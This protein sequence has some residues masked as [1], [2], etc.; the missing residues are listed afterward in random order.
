MK[1]GE[2]DPDRG[3]FLDT[4]INGKKCRGWLFLDGGGSD[5]MP[6][7]PSEIGEETTPEEWLEMCE[8]AEH[9]QARGQCWLDWEGQ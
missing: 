7:P 5:W 8:A 6:V 3:V 2:Y 9:R 1:H 4:T